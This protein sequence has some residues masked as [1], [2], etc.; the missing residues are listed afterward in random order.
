[1]FWKTLKRLALTSWLVFGVTVVSATEL[2]EEAS[3]LLKKA[4]QVRELST[5]LGESKENR[6]AYNTAHNEFIKTSR[7]FAREL[8]E[9]KQWKEFSEFYKELDQVGKQGLQFVVEGIIEE[10]FN[11]R[12]TTEFSK[13]KT[14][15]YFPGYGYGKPGYTYRK[16]QEVKREFQYA[17]WKDEVIEEETSQEKEMTME[18]SLALKL[19]VE[20]GELLEEVGTFDIEIDEKITQ[21]MKVK[22]K[23]SVKINTKQK[24]KFAYEKVW[25]EMWEAK[26]KWFGSLD[27]KL[28]GKTFQFD[29]NPTGEAVVMEATVE[30]TGTN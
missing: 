3:G 29:Q 14:Q 18:L 11:N 12:E 24:R 6:E 1:M 19:K 30:E 25:F 9:K 7:D 26:K 2:K 10:A 21:V 23:K 20:L 13:D 28:V 22:F 8:V 15:E 16:G 17:Y 27:W 4:W 5:K